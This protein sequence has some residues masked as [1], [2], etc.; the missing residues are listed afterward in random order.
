MATKERTAR[1]RISN[2]IAEL[3]S[4]ESMLPDCQERRA[5]YEM[6]LGLKSLKERLV[7]LATR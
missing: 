1:D 5:V 6:R 3:I 7:D 4:V 2:A